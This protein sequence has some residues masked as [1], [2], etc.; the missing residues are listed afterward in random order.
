MAEQP[1]LNPWLGC[2]PPIEASRSDPDRHD[3]HMAG[4]VAEADLVA[5]LQC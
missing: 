4:E 2:A 1:A 3:Q 5:V